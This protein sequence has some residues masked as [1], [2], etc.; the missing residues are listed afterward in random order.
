VSALSPLRSKYIS[1]SSRSRLLGL[2]NFAAVVGYNFPSKEAIRP[3]LEATA[4]GV[5]ASSAKDIAKRRGCVVCVGYPEIA[6]TRLDDGTA[7]D[8]YYNSLVFVS[9]EG[10]VLANYRK[11]F[12]Y[13]T[14]ETWAEEGSG[15]WAGELMFPSRPHSH[16]ATATILN[17][18]SPRQRNFDL[19]QEKTSVP[20][21][22]GICM[23]IN[24]YRFQAEL[25]EHKFA[26][27]VMASKA[28]LAIIS[29]A[30]LTLLSE[31][32][33]RGQPDEP[34]LQTVAYWLMR[35]EP[36]SRGHGGQD[37]KEP[38]HGGMRT[39]DEEDKSTTNDEGG[40][41]EFI[42]VFANRSGEESEARYAGSSAIVGISKKGV[43]CWEMLG[44]GEEGLCI[45]DTDL[46][47]RWRLSTVETEHGGEG[48]GF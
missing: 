16:S 40:E 4:S 34:D 37:R 23:D 26:D 17:N 8:R 6:T 3:F 5:T 28:K 10:E 47:A 30:W 43:R 36:L 21:A 44:R 13:Y 46:P 32:E 11:T 14:D 33:L 22:A 41:G 35:L 7:Q 29:M 15:F 12:L 48:E 39:P 42:V 45:A 27:H 25:T 31:D 24:S 1:L 19:P 38:A 20:A 2:T 9:N 18:K